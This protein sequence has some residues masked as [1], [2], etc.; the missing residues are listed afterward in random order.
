MH[1]GLLERLQCPLPALSPW[2]DPKR[3]SPS[4]SGREETDLNDVRKRETETETEYPRGGL[5]LNF[6]SV[7][8]A[9]EPLGNGS[10]LPVQ[11]GQSLHLVCADDSNPPAQLSWTRGSLTLKPS[12]PSHPG[13][14]RLPRVELGDHGKYVC[15]AQHLLGSLEAS[16][17][18]LVK[19]ELEH[20]GEGCQGPGEVRL[21]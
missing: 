10:S 4:R 11:E 12:Q 13:V 8:P 1:E 18:L 9:P 19:S 5:E 3:K 16:L 2:G 14:L 6:L 21:L 15:R 20:A 7:L 17:N